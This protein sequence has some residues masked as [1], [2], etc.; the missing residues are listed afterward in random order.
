[1]RL[2]SELSR[3]ALIEAAA[4]IGH[5]FGNQ[6]VPIDVLGGE[7]RLPISTSREIA[8]ETVRALGLRGA[9]VRFELVRLAT[10]RPLTAAHAH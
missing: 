9:E 3:E 5:A 10:D 8:G 7:I 6:H 1:V 2:S 4:R